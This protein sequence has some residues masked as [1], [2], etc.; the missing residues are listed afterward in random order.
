MVEATDESGGTV[1]MAPFAGGCLCGAVRYQ[2]AGEPRVQ[3][4]CHCKMCQRASGA[5][6][7]ALIM[8][9][10][11]N[12]TVTKGQTRTVPFSPRT[13]RDICDICAGPLFFRRDARPEVR[14]IYVGSLDDPSRFR[15]SMH[16][17]V[18]SAMPWLDIR[19]DAPRYDEKPE[20]MSQT[21]RYDP[22]SGRAEVPG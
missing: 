6:V 21:L 7:A 13:F 2:A 20:G 10:A 17:C 12:V 8:M 18:S 22:V 15:P 4:L 5:P 16:V 9:D 19:D 11:S 14:A 3:V 1:R